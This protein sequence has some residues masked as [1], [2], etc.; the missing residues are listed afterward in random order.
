M[1]ITCDLKIKVNQKL[2]LVVTPSRV[3]VLKASRNSPIVLKAL[4]QPP[5]VNEGFI[6]EE[7]FMKSFDILA[8]GQKTLPSL[9][10][11]KRRDQQN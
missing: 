7:N 2:A 11:V 5:E 8:K 6:L 9:L 1:Y 10:L 4:A 3:K